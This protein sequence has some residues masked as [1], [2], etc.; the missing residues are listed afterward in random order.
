MSSDPPDIDD[1]TVA[2][3]LSTASVGAVDKVT[4][5][6]GSSSLRFFFA[7]LRNRPS[8]AIGYAIVLVTALV[9]I[10]API[11]AGTT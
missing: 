2:L 5:Q 4:P 6:K 3:A 9:G 7:V 11:L 8:F 10:C 1:A